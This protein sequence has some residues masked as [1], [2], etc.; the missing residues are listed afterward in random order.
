MFVTKG[1][2]L[3]VI[4][5]LLVTIGAGI[6][7]YYAPRTVWLITG[8][9]I[10]HNVHVYK[11]DIELVGLLLKCA[12]PFILDKIKSYIPRPSGTSNVQVPEAPRTS[13]RPAFPN[14]EDEVQS[15]MN[16]SE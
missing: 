4:A 6:G 2:I 11:D 12:C 16:R 3:K 14:V 9:F 7:L 8:V 1:L 10:G 15:Y 13:N 5:G